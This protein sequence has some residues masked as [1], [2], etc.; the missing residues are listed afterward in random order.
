MNKTALNAHFTSN[1]TKRI[2]IENEV[3]QL[4]PKHQPV[5]KNTLS[6]CSKKKETDSCEQDKRIYQEELMYARSTQSALKASNIVKPDITSSITKLL[7]NVVL[8]FIKK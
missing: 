7:M 5:F 4:K 6:G 3:D 8:H 2:K 1:L